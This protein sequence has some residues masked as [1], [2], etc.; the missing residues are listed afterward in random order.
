[1]F[2]SFFAVFLLCAL[3]SQCERDPNQIISEHRILIDT[4]VNRQTK[5]LRPRLD[6]L[7]DADFDRMVAIAADSI[8]AIRLENIKKIKGN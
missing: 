3:C 6:S 2:R 7:C 5:V 8:M 1:M 4:L